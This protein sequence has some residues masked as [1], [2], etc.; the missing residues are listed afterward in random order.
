MHPRIIV[1]RQIF[2]ILCQFY[3]CCLCCRKFQHHHRF[4]PCQAS[5]LDRILQGN[6]EPFNHLH[7]AIQTECWEILRKFS[8]AFAAFPKLCQKLP[9]FA[10]LCE[11]F[12]A[13]AGF[14][15]FFQM[16]WQS[17]GSL[18][19]LCLTPCLCGN[20]HQDLP[21][22]AHPRNHHRHCVHCVHR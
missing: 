4:K 8:S 22:P 5:I 9:A 1:S 11:L 18:L 20:P 6:C 10:N 3:S 2:V 19:E 14:F 17:K 7:T 16:V 21:P 12:Q 15:S 13:F